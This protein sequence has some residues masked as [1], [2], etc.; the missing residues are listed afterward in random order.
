MNRI[1]DQNIKVGDVGYCFVCE[2]PEVNCV[3][4]SGVVKEILSTGDDAGKRHCYLSD[5]L[6]HKHTLEELE[7]WKDK[8]N[9]DKTKVHRG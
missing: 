8:Q 1:K 7:E 2:W 4:Y 3:F 6:W 9:T 5:R